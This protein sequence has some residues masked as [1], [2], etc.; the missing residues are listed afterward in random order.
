MYDGKKTVIFHGFI[1]KNIENLRQLVKIKKNF[2]KK[3]KRLK[4]K[5]FVKKILSKK[6]KM[7]L[8]SA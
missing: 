5:G 6:S 3:L 4:F 1:T 7:F 8:Y 2:E